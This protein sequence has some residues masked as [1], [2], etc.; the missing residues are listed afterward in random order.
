MTKPLS[1]HRKP[2]TLQ[3]IEL[4]ERLDMTGEIGDG[5]VA[6]FH[7]LASRARIEQGYA[8]VIAPPAWPNPYGTNPDGTPRELADCD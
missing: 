2:A 8:P 3:L 4:A 7:E 5:T 1:E 6:R